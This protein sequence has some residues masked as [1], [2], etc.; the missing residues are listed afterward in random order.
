MI[1]KDSTAQQIKSTTTQP[2]I[3]IYTSIKR[4]RS[5]ASESP[6]NHRTCLPGAPERAPPVE[7]TSLVQ[8]GV[9]SSSIS[10]FLVLTV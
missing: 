9:I 4:L 10:N 5:N 7:Q 3:Y 2:N 8:R 1:V 6:I